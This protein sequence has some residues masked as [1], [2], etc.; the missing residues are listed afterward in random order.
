[1]LTLWARKGAWLW[2]W[3]T[4]QGRFDQ[5][6][7]YTAQQHFCS[8]HVKTYA[9]SVLTYI[10]LGSQPKVHN[11]H[12]MRT[13]TKQAVQISARRIS[14][15]CSGRDGGLSLSPSFLGDQCCQAFDYCILQTYHRHQGIYLQEMLQDNHS[16]D[17]CN[18]RRLGLPL[19]PAVK[20][21]S[22][23]DTRQHEKWL[24]PAC[25]CEMLMWCII[26]LV[27]E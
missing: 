17:I 22:Q 9:S 23:P 26:E 27:Q 2:R 24:S 13:M 7:R 6:C 15:S 16:K 21:I 18:F 11:V 5:K 10:L 20:S 3:A 8:N 4:L 25:N 12:S 19:I 1:M 14:L